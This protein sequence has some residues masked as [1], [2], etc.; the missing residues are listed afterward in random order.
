MRP[1]ASAWEK[2]YS[3]RLEEE[4]FRRGISAPTVFH[5]SA[6]D[7][8]WVVHGDDFTWLGVNKTLQRYEKKIR[9]WYDIKLR[10]IIGTGPNDVRETI[11]LNRTIRRLDD[12]IEYEAD[13]KH[14][15]EIEEGLGLTSE[16]K[17]A[18]W[19]EKNI[20]EKKL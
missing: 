4:G 1:A 19:P 7:C 20:T 11:L 18:D 16:S 12:K 13:P 10:A 8:V 2:D 5:N 9:E 14:V 15:R 17:G 6:D 3:R